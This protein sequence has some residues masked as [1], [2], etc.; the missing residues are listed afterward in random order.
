MYIYMAVYFLFLDQNIRKALLEQF[1]FDFYYLRRML[2]D[3]IVSPS[4][5]TSNKLPPLILV[6]F[7]PAN[8]SNNYRRQHQ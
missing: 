8:T 2:H 1:T 3:A 5:N 6:I 4:A 7:P